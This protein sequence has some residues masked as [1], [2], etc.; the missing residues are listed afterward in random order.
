MRRYTLLMLVLLL[1]PGCT[2]TVVAVDTKPAREAQGD[3]PNA[4]ADEPLNDR[5]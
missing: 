1:L 2:V 5:R 4:D 3:A